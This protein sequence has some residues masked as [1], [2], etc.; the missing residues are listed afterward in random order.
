M[1]SLPI[2]WI[3]FYI[4][5]ISQIAYELLLVYMIP[6]IFHA[7]Y[8]TCYLRFMKFNIGFLDFGSIEVILH[9]YAWFRSN[10]MI[11]SWLLVNPCFY[12]SLHC[13]LWSWID[14]SFKQAYEKGDLKP[15]DT[16]HGGRICN[17]G[18]PTPTLYESHEKSYSMESFYELDW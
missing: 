2:A 8:F 17:D 6:K 18:R 13:K 16:P 7:N 9:D 4:M 3:M 14:K 1:I 15:N 10:F 12:P 11:L 5:I